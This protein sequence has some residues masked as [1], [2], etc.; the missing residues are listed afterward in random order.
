MNNNLAIVVD[1]LSKRY[2][3]GVKEVIHD[4]LATTILSW[5]KAPISNYKKLRSLSKFD[6]NEESEDIIWALRDLSFQVKE[7]EVLGIIGKNGAGKSTLLKVLSRITNPTSGKVEIAGRVSSL[8][9]VGTGFH[10]EL[11]GRENVYLN[12]T[13][14]GMSKKEI[15]RKFDEIVEFSGVKK[16]I[17]TPI[18]RYSS[19][20][21]VRLAFAVAA[22]IEPEILII[23]EVLAVGDAEFQKKCLGKMQSVGREGRTVLFVSHNMLAINQLCHRVIWLEDGKQ[24]MDGHPQ[25]IIAKYLSYGTEGMAT[26][27][28]IDEYSDA[29]EVV[30]ESVRL[31][32]EDGCPNAIHQFN[33]PLSVEIN[34]SVKEDLKNL[35][36][37]Y[38]VYNSTGIVVYES[39]DT[40]L[41]VYRDVVRKQG[42]YKSVCMIDNSLLLPDRYTISVSAFIDKVKLITSHETVITFDISEVGYNLNPE[43]L[44]V[45]APIFKWD[46]VKIDNL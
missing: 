3:I 11:T 33:A 27:D 28:N 37:C 42:K 43:R 8:L 32:A 4:S 20:M 12:G 36:I 24:K 30:V 41:P 1:N 5:A 45:V 13:I 46:T 10:P 2:R 15:D 16:F 44:G 25:D 29:Q 9:E 40:D 14:I 17:D 35:S 38:Q 31:L 22:H 26:W 19:G 21:A 6:D 18:K 23:D 34:Y 39:I 7:G